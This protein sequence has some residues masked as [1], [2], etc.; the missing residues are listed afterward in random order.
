MRKIVDD[1]LRERLTKVKPQI[2]SFWRKIAVKI[3]PEANISS[4]RDCLRGKSYTEESIENFE[5]IAEKVRAM[6]AVF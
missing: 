3:D 1:S 6:D 2:P 5:K 4:M